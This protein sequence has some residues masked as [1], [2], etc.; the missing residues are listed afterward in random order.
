MGRALAKAVRRSDPPTS[1]CA[2][3][4]DRP[5]AATALSTISRQLWWWRRRRW[6]WAV[7]RCPQRLTLAGLVVYAAAMVTLGA[8]TVYKTAAAQPPWV[9]KTAAA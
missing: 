3:D 2:H 1:S 8:G 5:S 6:W 7:A 4:D 9:H